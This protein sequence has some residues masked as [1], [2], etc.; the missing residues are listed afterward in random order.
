VIIELGSRY[1]KAGFAGDALP[2][3]VIGFGPEE[4]RRAGDF[5]KWNVGHDKDWRKR[6]QGKEWG[7][8]YELWKLDL[9]TVDLGLVGDR[10][11]RA[12]REASAK[13]VN[14]Y[15]GYKAVLINV[16]GIFSLIPG[17][18]ELL[19]YYPPLYRFLSYPR[20]SIAFSPI[21]NHRRYR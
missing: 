11:E 14:G 16:A 1:L 15:C 17:R 18:D 9:R 4:Q 3:A 10:I 20:P 6:I 2:K 8:G 12:I 7:S 21:S 19:W 13:L 5:R